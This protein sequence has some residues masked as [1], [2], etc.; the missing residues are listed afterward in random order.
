MHPEKDY[1]EAEEPEKEKIPIHNQGK[2][3]PD[4]LQYFNITDFGICEKDRQKHCTDL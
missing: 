3:Y 4:C 2:D 1:G